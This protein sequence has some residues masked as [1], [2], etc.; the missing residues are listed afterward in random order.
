MT[1]RPGGARPLGGDPDRA[2]AL[3]IFLLAGEPSG[4][5]IG[6]GLMA[7]LKR[8]YAGPIT[9]VGV[10][11][12][13][14]AAEGLDSLYP[15]TDIAHFGAAE[16]I[17]HLR[18]LL[19]RIRET[20]AIIQ[21]LRPHAAITIDIPGF[22]FK[23]LERLGGYG[24][25][26][27]HYVAPQVWA[28]KPQRAGQIAK[29]LDHVL[30]L[31]PFEPPY[32]EVEGLPATCVGH[33]VLESG[34]GGGDGAAFRERHGIAADAPLLCLLP[35]SRKGEVRRLFPRFADAVVRLAA[36]HSDLTVVI[37]TVATLV[38]DIRARAAKLPVPVV[39]VVGDRDRFD[40]FA[41]SRAALAASGTIA[42]E[43]AMAGTPS[44]I[45]YRLNPITAWVVRRA[46]RVSHVSLVNLLA[47]RTVFPEMLQ[48]ECRGDRLAGVLGGLLDDPAV[49][50]EQMRG[51][52]EAIGALRAGGDRP[53][54]RAAD[55]V[56]QVVR[57]GPRRIAPA[58][59]PPMAS[60]DG[61]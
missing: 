8:G 61:V 9:F 40:A 41:A 59:P 19:R 35:G 24:V 48:G 39:V 13:K 21:A 22:A 45:S 27:I 4:D 46:I 5:F 11:G 54:E 25:P 17:P 43:L 60:G 38:D 15:M 47:G 2:E 34:A 3:T 42:L 31:F 49:R 14:M 23:V 57:E 16:L 44:I 51:M 32:F 7:A 29:Y 33:P 26:L 37:P 55:V 58:L 6:A 56:L 28:W 50:T 10:G 52:E 20:V 18:L 30:C 53:S 12:P 1:D 36:T